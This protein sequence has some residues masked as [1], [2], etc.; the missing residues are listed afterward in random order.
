MIAR[1]K[2]T[3]FTDALIEGHLLR[4]NDQISETERITA[5]MI[6]EC[7]RQITTRYYFW[8]ENDLKL[9]FDFIIG[10]K[11]NT[12]RDYKAFGKW[13]TPKIMNCMSG[14]EIERTNEANNYDEKQKDK[15]KK[16]A[17][18]VDFKE[19]HERYEIIKRKAIEESKKKKANKHTGIILKPPTIERTQSDKYR[20]EW[21]DLTTEA[22][23][24]VSMKD[25]VEGKMNGTL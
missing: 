6:K 2:G 15:Y 25:Y 1:D 13:D 7:T 5:S 17:L 23:K 18:D 12:N 8:N 21:Q 10:G 24:L 4:L 20:Q 16:E 22:K 9:A 19:M 14:F 11:W 3:D